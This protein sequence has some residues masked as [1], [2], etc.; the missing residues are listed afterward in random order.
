MLA[1]TADQISTYYMRDY[2]TTG[3]YEPLTEAP[4]M[5]DAID[6]ST[7]VILAREF[8]QSGISGLAAVSNMNKSLLDE[9]WAR[10]LGAI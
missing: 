8:M 10:V 5:I 9:L 1:Q 2:I 7:I 4:K 3:T 6:K